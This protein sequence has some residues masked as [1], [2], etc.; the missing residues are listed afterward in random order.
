MAVTTTASSRDTRT[1]SKQHKR[2]RSGCFTCRLRRKKCDEVKPSCKA[3]KHL[4]LV[5]DYKRPTWWGN[6]EARKHEK[7]RIKDIIRRTQLDK[8]ASRTTNSIS[9][10]GPST[11]PGLCH[12]ISTPECHS[13]SI[14]GSYNHSRSVSIDQSPH[15]HDPEIYNVSDPSYFSIPPQFNFASSPYPAHPP[16]DVDVKVDRQV[17]VND[18]LTR[19]DSTLSSYSTFHHT[20]KSGSD[21]SPCLSDQWVE[22]GYFETTSRETLVADN[23]DYGAFEISPDTWDPQTENAIEIEEREGPS[24]DYFFDHVAPLLYPVLDATQ[25]GGA[26]TKVLL[27]AL[28]SNSSFLHT[29]LSVSAMHQQ[30]AH[31][32]QSSNMDQDIM[33]QLGLAVKGICD[34]LEHDIA[35]DQILETTLAMILYPSSVGTPHDAP[36]DIAWHQHFLMVRGLI[37]RLSLEESIL[38]PQ[39]NSPPYNIFAMTVTAWIDILGATMRGTSPEFCDTWRRLNVDQQTVGL[40]DVMGC[41]DRIMYLISEIACLEARKAEGMD[42]VMLCSYVEILG[43]QISACEAA[44]GSLVSA[45]SLT[46][47]IRPDQLVHNISG[48]FRLAARIYLCSLIP[49]LTHDNDVMVNLLSSFTD[50]MAYIPK[51]PGGFDR[52][53]SWPL[54]IAGSVSIPTSSFRDMLSERCAALGELAQQGSLARVQSV[55]ASLWASN[56]FADAGEV[57]HWRDIMM[58][59]GMDCLIV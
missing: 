30:A 47:D 41:D 21:T 28:G 8:K 55:L 54:L 17:Y 22:H 6:S 50:T 19:R 5:C 1:N 43:N 12:S 35:H 9:S 18:N 58:E 39:P 33:E 10:V 56:D 45:I 16:F 49:G 42:E 14:Y 23:F 25:E 48:V 36:S 46:G 7:E 15:L 27:P 2:S 20:A 44:P 59:K 4:G 34:N 38:N 53:L 40:S 26:R 51:G 13:D 11:P 31:R 24:L 32:S 3:C 37:E 29:C 52:A 57:R